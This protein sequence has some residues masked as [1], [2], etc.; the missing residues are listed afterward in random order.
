VRPAA[1]DG[2]GPLDVPATVL[3]ARYRSG[4]CD[5]LEVAAASHTRLEGIGV[6]LGAVT[7]VVDPELVDAGRLSRE[8]AAGI[9]RGP[10]HGIP[11]VVKEL[12]DISGHRRTAGTHVRPDGWDVPVAADAVVVAALRAAGAVIVARARTHEFAWGITTRHPD[13]GGVANPLDPTRIAG[14][15]S[16]GVAAL[17]AAGCA[18]IG[19]GTDTGGSVRIPASFCGLVGWK[20]AVGRLSTRGVVPLA[21]TFDH[22]GVLT[23]DEGDAV[24]VDRVLGGGLAPTGPVA[25]QPDPRVVELE[26]P[27]LPEVASAIRG[28]LDRAR[29][30]IRVATS[31]LAGPGP[32][33]VPPVGDLVDQYGVLQRAEALAVHRDLLGTWPAQA[34]R[35]GRD[36][37][38]R[39]REAEGLDP[40]SVVE[41]RLARREAQAAWHGAFAAVEADA[42]VL[43][44]Q[45]CGPALV[46][47]PDTAVVD[48]RSRP[49]RDAVMPFTVPANVTG[50]PALVVP[51]GPGVDGLPASIQM[52]ARPGRE[53][54]LP[55]LAARIR[56]ARSRPPG[57]G[58][59][60]E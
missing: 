51:V 46:D 52:I 6:E 38:G 5:P 23:R 34:D 18:P 45:A 2:A 49:L 21:P 40:A 35:Y 32:D 53:H 10:L 27:S 30:R 26:D 43:P 57:Q 1:A 19:I 24:L 33:R 60:H 12:I 39:M 54:L 20:P 59:P 37:A 7:E 8:L 41:A 36:V 47:D 58:A 50:W 31:L 22:V 11:V 42:V 16:G 15:S 48:G 14:G 17:V 44:A 3:A 4:A 28:A 55:A 29:A 13:G 25:D 9:D 56:G